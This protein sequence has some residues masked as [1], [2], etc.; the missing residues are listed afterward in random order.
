MKRHIANI[1]YEQLMLSRYIIAHHRHSGG[2]DRSVY[3]L[4]SRIEGQGPMSIAELSE[5][6]RLDSS[7]LQRQVTAAIKEGYVQRISDPEGQLA[8]KIALTAEGEQ[9]LT[10]ARQ[11]S[12]QKLDRILDEWSE[13][14]IEQFA[15]YLN[16]FNHSIEEYSHARRQE[17]EQLLV[18]RPGK[19][20]N[21]LFQR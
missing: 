3:L 16:R 9:V 2:L 20:G 12:C 10:A 21:S 4:M 19:A 13:Q 5:T 6:L 15:S 7:T 14:D 8:R 1:E 18:S 11:L 17:R